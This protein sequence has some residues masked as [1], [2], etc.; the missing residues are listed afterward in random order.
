[1]RRKIMGHPGDKH[2]KEQIKL[3]FTVIEAQTNCLGVVP[4]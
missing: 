3:P 1:M 4:S 2:L